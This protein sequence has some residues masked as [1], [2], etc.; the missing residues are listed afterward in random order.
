MI[1]RK[2]RFHWMLI[3]LALAFTLSLNF[4]F[5]AIQGDN[6]LFRRAE[7]EAEHKV[8][9]REL[10]ALQSQVA[11]MENLTHRLSDDYL[12]VDLLDERTRDTLG[13]VRADEIVIH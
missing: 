13:Y 10:A 1:P 8:L 6:G 5:A 7:V 11:E 2:T 9:A 3:I 4:V 12:D